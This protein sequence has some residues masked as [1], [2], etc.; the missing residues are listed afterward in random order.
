VPLPRPKELRIVAVPEDD[1]LKARLRQVIER[2]DEPVAIAEDDGGIIRPDAVVVIWSQH[3]MLS[4]AAHREIVAW[5]SRHVDIHL[6]TSSAADVIGYMS[7]MAASIHELSD[8]VSLQEWLHSVV[9]RFGALP[10]AMS[11]HD[12][13][14][15][16]SAAVAYNEALAER[17]S[18]MDVIGLPEPLP[19]A[20][21]YLPLNVRTV[22]GLAPTHETTLLTIL[23][24]GQPSRLVVIGSAGSG[25]TTL[26]DYT[27]YQLATRTAEAT[28]VP[29]VVRARDLMASGY[30]NLTDY[31]RLVVKGVVRRVGKQVSAALLGAEEFGERGTVLM[32]DGLDELRHEDRPRL[33][34]LLRSFETEFPDATILLSSRPNGVDDVLWDEYQLVTLCPVEAMSARQYIRKFAPPDSQSGLLELLDTSERLRELAEVP[35]MLALMCARR[36]G[37]PLPPRRAA[38]LAMCVRSLLSRRP[39]PPESGLTASG[40]FE[41]IVAVSDRLFR[42][43]A[44]GQHAEAEF[45]FALQACLDEG[46]RD[47]RDV[48][49]PTN[50]DRPQV[51]LEHLVD[52][53]GL[54]QRVAGDIT[55]VH[56]SLWEYFVAV[57]L[58]RRGVNA[59]DEL[60]GSAVWEE[61]IRLMMGLTDEKQA[62]QVLSHLWAHDPGLALRAASES[63][64]DL[65]AAIQEL[66]SALP[67]GEAAGLVRDMGAQLRDE[68]RRAATER[69]IL[70]TLGVLLPEERACETLWEGLMLLLQISGRRAEAT[71]L[72]ND[73]FQLEA[74]ESR[75][76]ALLA[77]RDSGVSFTAI[78][79]GS[80][81]MGNGEPGRAVD[82]RP[83]HEVVLSSFALS[84]TTVTNAARDVFPF[85]I[86]D[87]D[88]VRSPGPRHPMIRVTWYE[89]VMFA[90]WFGCRLP[91]EAEWEYACRGGGTDDQTLFLESEISDYAW[92]AGNAGNT[93]HPV[94]ERKANSFGLYDMLGNVR[95]W[96][97][98][99]YAKDYYASCSATG[100]V[101]DPAGP[102]DGQ[103]K[104]LRGGCFDWNTANLVP[105]YRNSNLPNN[106]GFQNG[107]RLVRGLP[108]TL[109]AFVLT[110][111]DADM[112]S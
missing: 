68:S 53:T 22:D 3:I 47:R 18:L 49:R 42:L 86:G 96:C 8:D 5:D 105:T 40:L 102:A 83:P 54:L 75:C 94:G 62:G 97:S 31:L 30:D 63:P 39:I 109:R 91:T 2:L 101:T 34:Q 29:L 82:E 57:A 10:D 59:L 46:P 111:A 45:L 58:S 61:P 107:L 55:F 103:V 51:V 50:V 13:S 90:V 12:V 87:P 56:R 73:V 43:D 6:L 110:Q 48:G 74:A 76:D 71:R 79:D 36:D 85:D 14:D 32:V 1:A 4:A 11:T 72:I 93:T 92:F 84:I 95:E 37:Q 70:D 106:P 27:A 26:L 25:K 44:T 78:P 9:L 15:F 33:R 81:V 7:Q 108:E 104:I 98:D 89:A 60:V 80:F 20:D 24:A 16:H 67:A 69:M 100:P 77:M 88:D 41:C 65:H 19:I 99:W 64:A 112:S 21:V 17:L 28:G 52:G 66:L 38:L 23:A 35:F